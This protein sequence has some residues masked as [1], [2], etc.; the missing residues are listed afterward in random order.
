M[1]RVALAV[2]G[3]FALAACGGDDEPEGS[4]STPVS[5]SVVVDE[6][7][8]ATVADETLPPTTLPATTAAPTIVELTT[9]TV[10]S[11][12]TV[13]EVD[14]VDSCLVGE[15]LMPTTS[16]DLVA[17]TAVPLSGIRVV[18]GSYV[19]RFGDDGTFEVNVAFT[20]A[21]TFGDTTA[22][23]DIVWTDTGTWGTA[24]DVVTVEVVEHEWAVTQVRQGGVS[25]PGADV[26]LLEPPAPILGGPYTC[27]GNELTITATNGMLD[28]PLNFDRTS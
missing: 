2:V 3:V 1:R 4:E 19:Q 21:F 15:W 16:L 23:A 20:A 28:I 12:E 17:A 26:N 14:E 9:T 10:I 11:G 5:T 25:L 6:T 8:A 22:E 13:P 24:D 27:V 18:G 7:P